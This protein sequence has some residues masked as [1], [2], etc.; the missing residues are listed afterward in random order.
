MVG[1]V[2]LSPVELQTI[3]FEVAKGLLLSTS[4]PQRGLELYKVLTAH[5]LLMGLST[6]KVPD[7]TTLDEHIKKSE[8]YEL[9]KQITKNFWDR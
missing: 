7:Y 4:A 8:R 1:T 5:C 2:R 9:I 6:N 3:L